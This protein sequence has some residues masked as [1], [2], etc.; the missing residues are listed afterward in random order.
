MVVVITSTGGVTKRVVA[1]DDAGRPRPR[2]L[3]GAVPERAASPGSSSARSRCA[4]GSTTR[5]SRPRERAFLDALRP[6]FTERSPPSEQRLYVGGAAGLLD[7]VRGRRARGVP[8]RCSRCSSSAR[9]CSTCSPRRSTRGGR[10]SASATSSTHPAL[11]DARARRRG[12]RAREP[13]A[14]RGQPAR[15]GADGLRQGDPLGPRGRR[16]S[17][18]ASSR[19]STRTTRLSGWRR[20]ERDYYELLGVARTR[21][22]RRDQEGVPRARARAAPGRLRGAGRARSASARSSRRTRCSRTPRRASST[23]ATATRA[24]AAAASRR[25]LRLRQPRRPLLRLL[26]RRPLRRRRPRAARPR[27]R[28]RAP[29]SRSSSSR[30]RRASTREVPFQVAVAV[31]DA[32]AASGAEPGTEPV[33]LRRPAAAR[34]RLQQ[35]S[36]SVFG[37][38]VRTQACPALR[39][40][41]AASSSTRARTCDG[42]GRD[43]EER[44]LEV[45]IPPGIHDGQRIRLARRGPCGRARRRAPATSTSRCASGRDPRFVREGDDIFSTVDLT[46]DRRRRSARRVA[47]ADARRRASSSSSSRARSRARCAC[48]AAGH[49]GA[50]GLRPR[51]P[52]RARQRRRA[53]AADRR[54]ARAARASS[55][56]SPTRRRTGRTRASSRS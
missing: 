47:V 51:R 52:S 24:C 10:S 11:R 2:R 56:S 41:R 49:A 40:R 23:T 48:C 8:A 39:R 1:F 28:R 6:A 3:G 33:D 22:R 38:F 30:R 54:A 42:A 15:P 29:R 25:R 21:D 37:E 50:A 31:R 27:R 44:T 43:V 35:V 19:T 32:A 26:R 12:L 45:E 9:R 55:S 4:G 36:R 16:T 17:S 7:D 13:H 5:A 14:R 53:A 20:R 34:G 18:R 46:I